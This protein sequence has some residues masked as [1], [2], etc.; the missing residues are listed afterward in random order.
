MRGAALQRQQTRNTIL[1]QLRADRQK[2]GLLFI[3][4]YA[5]TD[6]ATLCLIPPRTYLPAVSREAMEAQ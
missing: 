3:G 2:H 1:I 5:M 4:C 6:F